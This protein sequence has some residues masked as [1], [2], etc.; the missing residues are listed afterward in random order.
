MRL[1]FLAL[2]VIALAAT[3]FGADIRPGDRLE[4]V[5]AAL[6]K[7]RGEVRAGSHLFLDYEQG[8][9]E[10]KS[11]VVVKAD[12]MTAE[13]FLAYKES[14]EQARIETEKAS[15]ARVEAGT[16]VRDGKLRDSVFIRSPA[17]HR[18]TYWR[19]FRKKYPEVDVEAY[20][21]AA[22]QE[23]EKDVA[24]KEADA[25]A[26]RERIAVEEKYAS[27]APQREAEAFR[28]REQQRKACEKAR[29]DFE[30]DDW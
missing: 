22:R 29:E 13:E 12:V 1:L 16:R 9:I 6:G 7:P 18:F 27:E 20:L 28:R 3:S 14:V 24:N 19:D 11:N 17:W 30:C 8:K 5:L 2:L 25:R 15:A 21:K 4:K 23:H 10:L 26:E